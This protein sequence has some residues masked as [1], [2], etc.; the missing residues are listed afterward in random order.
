MDSN[1]DSFDKELGVAIIEDEFKG[2]PSLIEKCSTGAFDL[3]TESNSSSYQPPAKT[4][5][6]EKHVSVN[7]PASTKTKRKIIFPSKTRSGMNVAADHAW[8]KRGYD[9]LTGT[10][11]VRQVTTSHGPK[12]STPTEVNDSQ[13][14]S[15]TQVVHVVVDK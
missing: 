8:Q 2:D 14:S 13:T 9:S 5:P 15:G 10:P 11:L 6:V 4:M 3:L 1:A 12:I 7:R